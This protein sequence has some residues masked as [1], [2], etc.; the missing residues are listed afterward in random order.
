V[1]GAGLADGGD[2][3]STGTARRAP[4]DWAMRFVAERAFSEL[5]GNGS[6]HGP[7]TGA[8]LTQADGTRIA[9]VVCKAA[10][11]PVCIRVQV[12]GTR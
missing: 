6:P 7:G 2:S 10:G 3:V 9:S 4:A 11:C 8:V 1:A 12:E 5:H